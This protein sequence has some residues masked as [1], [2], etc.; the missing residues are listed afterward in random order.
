M[1][2]IFAFASHREGMPNSL[3]EALA[4]GVPAIAFAIP[5]VLEIDAGAGALLL[6]PPLDTVQYAEALVQLAASPA[7][8]VRLGEKGRERV[9]AR[10][11]VRE[12]GLGA[13]TPH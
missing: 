7:D 3:L 9:L 8:R 13:Q 5:A 2:D 11:M 1:P 4:I 12:H 6:V 10:F